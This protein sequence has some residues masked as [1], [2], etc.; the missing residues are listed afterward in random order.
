MKK[1]INLL[2]NKIFLIILGSLLLI[3]Q[4]LFSNYVPV[5]V[6]NI[7]FLVSDLTENIKVSKSFSVPFVSKYNYGYKTGLYYGGKPSAPRKIKI[8]IF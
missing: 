7:I 3:I 4:Q 6:G 2:T 1:I 8:N 5:I